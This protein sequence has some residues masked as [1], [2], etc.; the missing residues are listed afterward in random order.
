G[1]GASLSI[2]AGRHQIALA[3]TCLAEDFAPVLQTVSELLRDPMF[4][5]REV[6]T[7][8]AEHITSIREEQD[9][10]ASVAVDRLVRELYEGHPYG[11]RVAG[12]LESVAAIDRDDLVRF[13]RARFDPT[14]LTV[15]VVGSV[16]VG[17]MLD[18]LGAQFGPWASGAASPA[19]QVPD[20]PP[21]RARRRLSVDMP[22]KFQADVAY[23]FVGLRRSDPHYMAA[24]VMNNVLGQ[25]ALGGRLGDSIRERQGMAYY[26]FSSLDAGIGPGPL[27]IRAGVAAENVNRTIASIDHEL[28]AVRSE[29]FSER[30]VA[31]SRQYLAG[32]LPRQLETNAG[33]ASF[34]LSAEVFGLGLDYDRRLPDLVRE[35][36]RDAVVDQAR[37][38]LDTSRATIVVAGPEAPTP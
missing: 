13:H 14:A 33:I 3:A 35:V 5:D 17:A 21:G 29:G 2:S 7:R 18:A 36:S 25:Y 8:R 20:A 30:E 4:P 26:V 32:A 27:T 10:P 22:G 24:A 12:T 28:D 23:G 19:A 15:V 1:R 34:L 16:P 37:R 6:V 9:D 31:D 38:L 11:R